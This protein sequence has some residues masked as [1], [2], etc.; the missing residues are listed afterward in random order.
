MANKTNLQICN[1]R[2]PNEIAVAHHVQHLVVAALQNGQLEAILGRVDGEHARPAVT[3]EAVDRAAL[4]A[5]NIDW[6]IERA[7]DA[8]VTV[9]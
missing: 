4:D 9:F 1:D 8:V 6:Q 3:I 5:R 7:N 2:L